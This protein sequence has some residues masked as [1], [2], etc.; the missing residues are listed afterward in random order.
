MRAEPDHAVRS[1]REPIQRSCRRRAD[2]V[3]RHASVPLA[4]TCKRPRRPRSDTLRVCVAA[5]TPSVFSSASANCPP[6][7][8]R[9]G[10]RLRRGPASASP[11]PCDRR[12]GR[13]PPCRVCRR[14]AALDARRPDRPVARST[15][16]RR[17]L[18]QIQPYTCWPGQAVRSSLPLI[19]PRRLGSLLRCVD[20]EQQSEIGIGRRSS[21]F[22]W[23]RSASSAMR[24]PAQRRRGQNMRSRISDRAG[25]PCTR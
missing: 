16:L 15:A 12:E 2:V 17:Q 6:A 11:R 21:V 25:L 5:G 20:V 23:L 13:V 24:W 18:R 22:G 10:S 4:T 9:T 7:T 19:S 8:S 3:L 14:T 1:P